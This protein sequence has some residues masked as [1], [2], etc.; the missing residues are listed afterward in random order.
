MKL[1]RGKAHRIHIQILS[2]ISF[3]EEATSGMTSCRTWAW[4]IALPVSSWV[5]ELKMTLK[6]WT[7]RACS[8]RVL[9][10]RI[11]PE[12]PASYRHGKYHNI[13]HWPRYRLFAKFLLHF[14][15]FSR[16][17]CTSSQRWQ[18]LRLSWWISWTR[19]RFL[20]WQKPLPRCKTMA[21]WVRELSSRMQAAS[22]ED[23]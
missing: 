10:I 6:I 22:L 23:I 4:V 1:L 5:A 7:S 19:C 18:T 11:R 21:P 13:N 17:V 15:R 16:A 8:L 20:P 12:A 3:R 2:R 9:R 14:I